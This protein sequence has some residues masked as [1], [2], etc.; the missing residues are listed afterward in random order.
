MCT[1]SGLFAVEFCAAP[2][3]FPSAPTQCCLSLGDVRAGRCAVLHVCGSCCAKPRVCATHIASH[4]ITHISCHISHHAFVHC[5]V[6][7][8]IHVSIHCMCIAGLTV[9]MRKLG[10]GQAV[11]MRTV[12][13]QH[14]Y[15]PGCCPIQPEPSVIETRHHRSYQ[16]G[17]NYR[18]L[19]SSTEGEGDEQ[20]NFGTPHGHE[21]PQLIIAVVVCECA[22]QLLC[23]AAVPLRR[24]A[25]ASRQQG[26]RKGA[27]LALERRSAARKEVSTA[28]PCQPPRPGRPGHCM[29]HDWCTCSCVHTS[30]RD[31]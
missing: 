13:V 10:P 25:C 2:A 11:L 31:K 27:C 28:P 30:P 17:L 26:S 14:Q 19:Q 1:C 4:I 5:S 6:H 16:A 20:I 23:T 7:V 9:L 8:S 15:L 3:S 22:Q 12:C 29:S 24:G 18:P 21:D